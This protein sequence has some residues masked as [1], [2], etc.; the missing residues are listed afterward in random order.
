MGPV[1]RL[2]FYLLASDPGRVNLRVG[3]RVVL[4][5]AAVCVVLIIVDRW[6][7]MPTAA[8][9][10]GMLSAVQ[11]AAQIRDP[12]I[13]GRAV[14]RVYAAIAA[15]VVIAAI[16]VVRQ[17]VLQLDLVVLLVVFLAIYVSRLGLRWQAVGVFAFMCGIVGAYLKAPEADLRDIAIALV[18]SGFT[19]HLVRNFVMPEIASRDF[20]RV[21]GTTLYV[22]GQ[23]RQAIGTTPVAD[24]SPRSKDIMMIMRSLRNAIM[25]CES[26]L[27]PQTED[28]NAD[29]TSAIGLRFLDLQLAAETATELCIPEVA[30]RRGP[31]AGDLSHATEE[32]RQS[33]EAIRA[34]VKSLPDSLPKNVSAKPPAGKAKLFP[35]PGQW[36]KDEP[37]RRSLQ[38]TLACGIAMAGGEL[39]SSQRW[40]WAVMTAFLIFMNTQSGGAV[41][42]RAV[43]RSLGTAAGIFVGIA[44]ATLIHGNPY[45]TIPLVAIAIFTAFYITRLSNVTM[46]FCINIAISLIY[47]YIGIFTPELLLLRLLETAVGA[48]AGMFV[49]LMILPVSAVRKAEETMHRLTVALLDLIEIIIEDRKPAKSM[50]AGINAVDHAYTDV[51]TACEPMRSAWTLGSTDVHTVNM[52]RHAYFMTHAAH[53]LQHAFRDN[54]PNANEAQALRQIRD[55]LRLLVGGSPSPGEPEPQFA[56]TIRIEGSE[57]RPED[58]EIRYAVE[59]L[60]GILQ[61]LEADKNGH[62]VSEGPLEGAR[63]A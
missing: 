6:L 11:G 62:R 24:G 59:T 16:S 28:K 29:P 49:S 32:L 25:M 12:T 21:V 8:L 58:N 44:L 61:H 33:E 2:K 42:I 43:N 5:L 55:R 1:D 38:V 7:H 47:G 4:T 60:L 41:A 30:G 46:M 35:A 10:L 26:Y 27:P 48:A 14:T 54:P 31:Q 40:F 19:A 22:S 3:V 39:L 45:W 15:F 9:T 34:A 23:L 13:A 53:L 20:R 52:M 57:T 56:D 17:S 51:L 18:I 50:T 37:L 36:L 63:T